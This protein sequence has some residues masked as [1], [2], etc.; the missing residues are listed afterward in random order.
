[1]ITIIIT[2]YDE[3]NATI[4]AIQS[5]LSQDYEGEKQI[6]VAEPFEDNI[7]E[8]EAAFPNSQIIYY[9]DEGK[10]KSHTLNFLLKKYSSNNTNDLFIFTD[11]DVY[12]EKESLKNIIEIFNDQTIGIACGRP[13]SD[14]ERTTMMGYWSHLLFDEMN[15]TRIKLSQEKQFF[16]VTGYLFAMRKGIITKFESEAS[17]DNVLPL[18]FWKKEYKIGYAEKAK[19]HVLNPTTYKDW[20]LQKKRNIKGHIALQ[21]LSIDA[22]R[23]NTFYGEAMRGIKLFFSYPRN[24]RETYWTIIAMI[25]RLHVWILAFYET[26][27]KKEKYKDGWREEITESTRPLD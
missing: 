4:K 18:L 13:V 21:K 14:N 8:F 23:K 26:K 17:E 9:Q 7:W 27:I 20:I 25:A 19:V 6:I 11:G 22:P 15:K 5:V 16:E 24:P 3:P 1:M 2:S 10:G 12:L